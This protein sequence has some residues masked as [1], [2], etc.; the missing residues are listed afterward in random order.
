MM[1]MHFNYCNDLADPATERLKN[2]EVCVLHNSSK[3]S[4]SVQ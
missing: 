4:I 2:V 3:E 1:L